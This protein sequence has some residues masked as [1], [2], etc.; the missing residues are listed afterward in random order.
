MGWRGDRWAVPA[1]ASAVL[2]EALLCAAAK[3]V[4]APGWPGCCWKAGCPRVQEAGPLPE[5]GL[6]ECFPRACTE[7]VTVD[8]A[9]LEDSRGGHLGLSVVHHDVTARATVQLSC[10]CSEVPETAHQGQT[11]WFLDTTKMGLLLT[12]GSGWGQ[13]SSFMCF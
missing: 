2:I 11:D 3:G 7:S 6:S 4:V 12:K 9:W 5:G 13:G 10:F 8:M 1:V